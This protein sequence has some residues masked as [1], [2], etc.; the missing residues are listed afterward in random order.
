[1]MFAM[2]VLPFALHAQMKFHDVEVNNAWGSVKSIE[3]TSMGKTSSIT[4]SKDGKMQSDEMREA[5]YD[6]NGFLES[7]IM[8]VGGSTLVMSYQWADGQI[9]TI[10]TTIP[11]MK[12]IPPIT[13]K[14]EYNETGSMLIS[15][16]TE[17]MGVVVR[18]T[19]SDY[20]FD[21][22]GN[23]ISR[24]STVDGNT[25]DETRKITYY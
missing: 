2:N 25:S 12:K 5:S 21:S 6:A 15:E 9:K 8:E 4:F 18:I 23:W 20:V 13:T 19:Y 24:K 17:S 22:H 14:R 11:E 7:A 3:T 1:M 10:T 16:S